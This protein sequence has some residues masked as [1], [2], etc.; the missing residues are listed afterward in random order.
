LDRDALLSIDFL[1]FPDQSSFV[2]ICQNNFTPDAS[3][4]FQAT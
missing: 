1:G 3:E 4:K 2:V